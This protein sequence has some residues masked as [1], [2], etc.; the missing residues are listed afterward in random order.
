MM[1]EP[2]GTV[3]F[4]REH[5]VPYDVLAAP[6][7]ETFYHRVMRN[8]SMIVNAVAWHYNG[9]EKRWAAYNPCPFFSSTITG[10]IEKAQDVSQ[11][12]AIYNNSGFAL[13]GLAD[14]IDS[15]Y[16]IK[17]AVYKQKRYTLA[18]LTAMLRK[19]YEGCELDRLYL[20]NKIP[21]VGADT[22]QMNAF[23]R[24]VTRDVAAEHQL[25]AQW[26]RRPV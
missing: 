21:K 20:Q 4:D 13:V 8:L 12:G 7:F 16:A 9:F 10:C 6:D 1:L 14:F 22:A 23:V 3:F 11:G 15:L 25:D 18:E 5:I 19:N 17:E 2:D 24:R 26:P